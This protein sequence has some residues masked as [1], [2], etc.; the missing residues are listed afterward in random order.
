MPFKLR[1]R[2]ARF[3]LWRL[4]HGRATTQTILLVCLVGGS[5]AVGYMAANQANWQASPVATVATTPR[6]ASAMD[7][8][9]AMESIQQRVMAAELG[10]L[11]AEVMR[12]RVMFLR[13]AELAELN[14]G[15]FDLDM[16]FKPALDDQEER[17]SSN[18][19]RDRLFPGQASLLARAEEPVISE[20]LPLVKQAL[21][22]ISEQSARMLSVFRER[23]ESFDIRVS[24]L[25]VVNGRVSSRYGY[26]VDPLS[27]RRQLH[28]GLDLASRP[29]SKI[30]ALADGIVT[31]SGKN[32]GYGNLVELEHADGFRTRY[33]HNSQ[34][35]VPLGGLV[36]K[37]QSIATMGSTGRST[38]THV[39]V[40]VRH[41]GLTVDP[42]LYIR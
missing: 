21:V 15:E 36:K 39:H 17:E 35:L 23:R 13:L 22:H 9:N 24:G 11:Q 5:A 1:L 33:A 29:G 38:G 12:L 10:K 18:E 41:N 26:R 30:M 14:D 20:A 3:A 28:A 6:L 19:M 37:G 8:G 27:G 40:E 32:G 42:Q 4:K 31:Y 16:M 25:P 34:L 2:L 7:S